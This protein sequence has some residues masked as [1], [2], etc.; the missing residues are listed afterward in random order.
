VLADDRSAAHVQGRSKPTIHTE[1]LCARGGADDIDDG[2]Y[3]ADFVEMHA[4]NGD[5]MNGGFRLA[6]QLEGAGGAGFHRFSER[7][8]ANDCENCR[9]GAVRRVRRMSIV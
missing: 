7:G 2:V 9:Q 4:F 8:G 1:R 3:R 6:Q 5:G